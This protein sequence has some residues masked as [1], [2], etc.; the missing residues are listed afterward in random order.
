[1]ESYGIICDKCEVQIHLGTLRER[2]FFLSQT[3]LQKFLSDHLKC[4][5]GKVRILKTS[6]ISNEYKS[7]D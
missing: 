2:G 1:M 3:D 6:R 5:E 4:G 7:L